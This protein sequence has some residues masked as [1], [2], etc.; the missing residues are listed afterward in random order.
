MIT[1]ATK[2]GE[3]H[4]LIWADGRLVPSFKIPTTKLSQWIPK[5]PFDGESPP[6][7]V[8]STTCGY[9]SQRGA[10]ALKARKWWSSSCPRIYNLALTMILRPIEANN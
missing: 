5:D 2:R 10:Q 9:T 8:F 7:A 3:H 6:I 4:N 1:T